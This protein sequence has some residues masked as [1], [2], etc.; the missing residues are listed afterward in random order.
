M[1]AELFKLDPPISS[2]G[3]DG[4]V[5]GNRGITRSILFL[6]KCPV[7]GSCLG[8]SGRYED[9]D[10]AVPT[11]ELGVL[12]SDGMPLSKVVDARFGRGLTFDVGS[13]PSTDGAKLPRPSSRCCSS[14]LWES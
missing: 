10:A 7:L 9:H 11:D 2:V 13:D 6:G 14:K 12:L 1:L 4:A 3:L 5:D 8:G